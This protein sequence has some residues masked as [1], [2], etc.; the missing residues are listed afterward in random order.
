MAKILPNDM[1]HTP[2]GW[3]E[4]NNWIERHNQEDRAHLYTVALMAWNLAA[5]ITNEDK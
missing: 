1:F 3:T 4:I 2:E 5:K